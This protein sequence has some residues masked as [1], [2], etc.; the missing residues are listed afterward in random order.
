MSTL[1]NMG[2]L[3]GYEDG[4]FRPNASITRAEFAKIAVSFFDYEGIGAD[5]GFADVAPGSWYESL[6]PPR[7]R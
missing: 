6:S 1:S 2:I 3:G 5:S 7:R 4:T